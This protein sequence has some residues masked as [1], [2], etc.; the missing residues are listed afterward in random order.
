MVERFYKQDPLPSGAN[1]KCFITT[2]DDLDQSTKHREFT[3]LMKKLW[4]V[5]EE[6]I[7]LIRTHRVDDCAVLLRYYAYAKYAH[8]QTFLLLLNFRHIGFRVAQ[9]PKILN[10]PQTSHEHD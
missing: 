2:V 1:H 3:F 4:W 7:L 6:V 9:S 10:L 5:V 8:L